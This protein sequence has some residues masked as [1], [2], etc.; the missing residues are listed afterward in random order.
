MKPVVFSILHTIK[1]QLRQLAPEGQA[2]VQREVQRYC[3]ARLA[4]LARPQP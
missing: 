1:V 4:E 3:Q 2:E